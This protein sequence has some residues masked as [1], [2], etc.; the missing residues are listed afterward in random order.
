M[1]WIHELKTGALI[2]ASLEVGALAGGGSRAG[3]QALRE[4]GALI[5]RAFQIA[6]DCLD[7]TG[8]VGELGKQPGQDV[9][10]GKLTY[11]AAIGL[12]ASLDEAR[13]L[14]DEAV[15]LASRVCCGG[16]AGSPLDADIRLMQDTA[17][18]LAARKT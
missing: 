5:G 4:Y 18:A 15:A 17:L 1:G 13:R 3:L 9:A 16:V 7:L 11:P 10:A 6:D 14:T 2:T 8:E 12:E